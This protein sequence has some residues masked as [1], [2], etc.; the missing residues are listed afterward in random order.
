M[1]IGRQWQ[2]TRANVKRAAVVLMGLTRA[3]RGDIDLVANRTQVLCMNG[4]GSAIGVQ[5]NLRPKAR[6]PATNRWPSRVHAEGLGNVPWVEGY[7]LAGGIG[8]T[9]IT[10]GQGAAAPCCWR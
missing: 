3:D 10:A 4:K 9:G 5:A 7:F 8:C 2:R 6:R 1:M